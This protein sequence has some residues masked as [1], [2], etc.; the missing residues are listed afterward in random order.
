M[1]LKWIIVYFLMILTGSPV[2]IIVLLLLFYGALDW[3]YFGF[4][5]Q[6]NRWFR[7]KLEIGELNRVLRINP[8]DAPSQVALGRAFILNGD[9]RNA[10]PPL[11][12]AFQK[13][14]DFPDVHY[15]LGLAYLA[16]G[17]EKEGKDHLMATI[18][19]DPRFQ[20]GEPY[21]K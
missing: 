4:F 12:A 21:L 8:H 6:V 7:R 5:P 15:Y 14:K 2:L 18:R 17:R 1:F 9:P 3:R 20:Y 11:E 13:M 16:S 10:I 19:M